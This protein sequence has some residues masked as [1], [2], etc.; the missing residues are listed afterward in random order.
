MK[1][2]G[3]GLTWKEFFRDLYR[4]WSNDHLSEMAGA[5]TYSMVLAVFPFLLF[6]VSVG[7]L[8]INPA[9]EVAIIDHLGRIAPAP[10]TAL[11]GNRIRK[12][13]A[14]PSAGFLSAGILVAIWA[15]SSGMVTLMT[16]LNICYGVRETRPFWKTRGLAV[17]LTLFAAILT[18]VATLVT[19][20]VPPILAHF[21]K[22]G[23]ALLWLRFPIAGVFIIGVWGVLYWLLP[24]VEQ[25]LR[26][27]TPGSVTG[28]ILW[29]VA[30]WGFSTYVAHFG[31]YEVTYGAL[32]GMVILLLWMWIS[33]QVFLLGAEI[34]VVIEHRSPE[35][36]RAGARTM[37]ETGEDTTKSQ[38]PELRRPMAPGQAARRREP[39]WGPRTPQHT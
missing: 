23:S 17:L 37:A 2:P 35:G 18:I 9:R 3:H 29:L 25:R 8:F 36:K 4:E 28:V 22:V 11:V 39:E 34:N 31:R 15:A 12:L 38:K 5:V 19:V 10:V 21:G 20:A 6:L 30:S 7:S 14:Q 32:T 24:D 1:L 13:A 16:A 33:A 26:F 27:I